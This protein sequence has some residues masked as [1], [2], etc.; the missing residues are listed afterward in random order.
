MWN[1]VCASHLI[2]WLSQVESTP[3]STTVSLCS[4]IQVRGISL[5]WWIV[6]VLKSLYCLLPSLPY[7]ERNSPL[8]QPL[9]C[10]P[11]SQGWQSPTGG[12]GCSTYCH[13]NPTL[14]EHNMSLIFL[15]LL[16]WYAL[17]HTNFTRRILWNLSSVATVCPASFLSLSTVSSR[18]S[19]NT[20]HKTR[21]VKHPAHNTS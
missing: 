8:G 6:K 20:T 11:D 10:Q 7:L 1:Y 14:M 15:R 5:A 18:H 9:L 3:S 2:L 19:L 4:Y 16:L 17:L 13:G 21:Y 12:G